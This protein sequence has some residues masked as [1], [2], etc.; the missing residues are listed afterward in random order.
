[1]KRGRP[2][3]LPRRPIFCGCEGESEQSYGSLIGRLARD[4]R[5]HVH[6]NVQKLQ[7][8]A[9][10]PLALVRRAIQLI[11]EIERRRDPFAAKAIFLDRGDPQICVQAEILA[12]AK[13][14][15]HLIWQEPDH[16]A[17]LLRHL[18][19]CHTLRPPAGTT[20][21]RLRREWPGY[22]KG[23][24]VSD[25]ATRINLEGLKAAAAVEGDLRCFLRELGFDC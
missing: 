17:I 14:I 11:N 4:N 22:A 7:P 9:G 1:M 5:F 3:I 20:L 18:P 2:Q 19:G 21:V 8:G 6:I 23:M 15:N 10:S 25:L 24:T 13:G 12:R 16:E